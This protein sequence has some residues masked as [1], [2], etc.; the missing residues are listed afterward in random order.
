MFRHVLMPTDGSTRS[1]AAVRLGMRIAQAH[2]AR[3]TALTVVD[4]G[5]RSRARA[6]LD[7]VQHVAAGNGVACDLLT[8]HGDKPYEHIVAAANKLGCDLIV[9]ATHAREGVEALVLGSQTQKVLARSKI[10]VVVCRE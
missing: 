9:M 7:F 1:E 6:H 4:V 3:A 5:Q 8:E 10:P 2:G